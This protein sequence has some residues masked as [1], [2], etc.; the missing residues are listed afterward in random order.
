VLSVTCGAHAPEHPQGELDRLADLGDVV[1]ASGARRRAVPELLLAAFG[2]G[3]EIRELPSD[4][5]GVVLPFET[6]V[7]IT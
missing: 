1:G 4:R 7:R 5:V 2:D 3:G 6:D